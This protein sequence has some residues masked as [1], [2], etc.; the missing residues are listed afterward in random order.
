MTLSLKHKMAITAARIIDFLLIEAYYT[1]Q[2]GKKVPF[3]KPLDGYILSFIK[4]L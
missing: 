1:D 2:T 4:G 3:Q